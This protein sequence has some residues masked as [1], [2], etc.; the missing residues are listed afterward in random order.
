MRRILRAAF[1]QDVEFLVDNEYDGQ[2]LPNIDIFQIIKLGRVL[3]RRRQ[4]QL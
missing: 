4:E 3:P 2:A 1:L